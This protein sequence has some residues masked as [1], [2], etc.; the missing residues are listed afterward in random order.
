[1]GESPGDAPAWLSTTSNLPAVTNLQA[2]RFPAATTSGPRN[3]T[4][5]PGPGFCEDFDQLT[6]YEVD[7]AEYERQLALFHGGCYEYQIEETVLDMAEHNKLLED[8][9]D[10]VAAIRQ[11]QK[12][13]QDEMQELDDELIAKW[14]EKKAAGKIPM[15]KVEALLNDPGIEKIS[16]PLNA[17]VWKVVAEEGQ[18]IKEGDG[19]AILEAM[20]LEISVRAEEGMNRKLEKLL[21]RPG[22]V[23]NAGDP[24]VLVRNG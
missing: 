24:L 15:E 12:R 5:C 14:T 4:H 8:T 19:V 22:D 23:V 18:E 7:E 16:S 13:A 6:Y 17:N 9:K 1:M 11:K 21:V 10:E 2:P 3:T 20:K